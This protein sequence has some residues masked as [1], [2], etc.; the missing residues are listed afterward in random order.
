MNPPRTEQL[1]ESLASDLRRWRVVLSPLTVTLLWF[2]VSFLWVAGCL[3]LLGPYRDEWFAQTLQ[4]PR[5]LLELLA[6]LG[7][8]FA[9]ALW[10]FLRSIRGTQARLGI[11]AAFV[12]A[13]VFVGSVGAGL[14]GHPAVEPS[15]AGKRETCI[16]EA[17]LISLPPL[18][19]AIGLI[20]RRFP[21]QPLQAAA[22]LAGATMVLPA[23]LMH[24]ACMCDPVHIFLSHILPAM[25]ATVVAT[26]VVLAANLIT[27][28][29]P[30]PTPDHQK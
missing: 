6:G 24:V 7:A 19:G 15:M 26:V 1:I 21:L 8:S 2:S 25:A 22:P 28:E 13:G 30:V 16:W 18:I 29:H 9:M 20:R 14:L 10:G 3:F 27:P 11:V 23:T 17:L 12:L 5:L 4:H